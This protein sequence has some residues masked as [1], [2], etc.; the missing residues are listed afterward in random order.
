MRSSAPDPL[1]GPRSESPHDRMVQAL[2][3]GEG[4]LR[5]AAIASELTGVEVEVLV[6]R[7][8]SDGSSGSETE[9]FAAALVAGRLPPWPAGVT[10]VAPIVVDGEP[11]GAVVARGELGPDGAEHLRSAARAALTGIAILNTRDQV[12]RDTAAGLIADLLAG[13]RLAASEIV[14]RAELHG[15]DLRG[16]FV[17]VC[18]GGPRDGGREEIAAALVAVHPG[19][20]VEAVDGTTYALVPGTELDTEALATRLGGRVAR[21]HSF[22]YEDPGQARQALEEAR[23][24]LA[25][26]RRADLLDTDRATWDNVRIIYGAYATQPARMREFCRRTVGDLV[27]RDAEE[28][29]RLQATFWAYQNANCNMNGAATQMVTHRHTVANRLRR[30]RQLTGL[31]PQRGYD[32]ELLG[33]ALRTHLVI[34]NSG[35]GANDGPP[36]GEW[37]LL[38]SNQ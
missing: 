20:L 27:R 7:P 19:T 24:L 25:L 23:T 2:L 17:A 14:R 29:G 32:R 12:R 35:G 16:G 28:G 3:A 31:D 22:P 8:G 21:A 10:E 11:Q 26:C 6:P 37:A 9:R 34:V 36:G 33:L 13:R 15:C 4:F 18:A 38:G 5:V 1:A 30:I